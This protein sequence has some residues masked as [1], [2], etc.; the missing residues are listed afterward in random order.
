MYRF[1]VSRGFTLVELLVVIAIIG[2]LAGLLLPAIQQAREAARRMSCSSNLRQLGVAVHNYESAH[3]RIPMNYRQV[4]GNAWEATSANVSLLPFLEQAP[5]SMQFETN[6]TNW[7]WTSGIG[8]LTR[9]ASFICPSAIEPPSPG[10]PGS[11]WV[12][13]PGTNYAWSTGSSYETNWAQNFNG[14]M[15]YHAR[16]RF[17]DVTDGL[18]NT[19]LAS[20]IISGSGSTGSSGRF[21]NDIFYVGNG[22]FNTIIDRNFPTEAEVTA[23]GTAARTAP[24]GYRA[25]HGTLWAWYAAGHSTFN[26]T[27][28]PNWSFPSTGGDCCPGVGHDWGVGLIP[29]RSKHVGGVNITM[30]DGSTT[31]VTDSLDLL[32][33]QRLGHRSDSAV[34]QDQINN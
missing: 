24:V 23:I 10:N 34:I 13:G 3:K 2:I 29:A 17:A 19:I 15:T 12:G 1:K 26:T 33:F 25:N 20:E 6:R 18:S 11:W 16:I 32:T 4:G 22:P 9:V 30:G 8:M 5:L 31:F 28:T 14:M 27:V 21:P 7:G